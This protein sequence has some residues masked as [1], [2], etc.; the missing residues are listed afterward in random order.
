MFG[1]V[2]PAQL[3]PNRLAR[4]TPSALSL[5]RGERR[6]TP[7]AIRRSR[8][9]PSP[10]ASDRTTKSLFEG[11]QAGSPVL[12]RHPQTV[13]PPARPPDVPL[14]EGPACRAPPGHLD[15]APLGLGIGPGPRNGAPVEAGEGRSTVASGLAPAAAEGRTAVNV[16]AGRGRAR[17][18]GLPAPRAPAA[19]RPGG[20]RHVRGHALGAR[21]GWTG[22]G[23]R[24][25]R[26]GRRTTRRR[27]RLD[28]PE[29]PGEARGEAPAPSPCH[30]EEL[31]PR[32]TAS[33]PP[34]P[35]PS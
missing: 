31:A 16:P 15:V 12:F 24:R 22:Q 8:P 30:R 14:A 6:S 11:S 17:H 32:P 3:T 20:S 33:Q 25:G 1:S 9:G 13:L 28:G 2:S 10:G 5:E 4:A 34:A 7:T 27:R 35:P 19:P 23:A 21:A 29:D 18:P 26:R